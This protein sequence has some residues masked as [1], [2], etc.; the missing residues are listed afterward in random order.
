MLEHKTF[1]HVEKCFLRV[2]RAAARKKLYALR[3]EQDGHTQLA[4]LFRAIVVSEDAQA[5][6]LLL[7]L[8]GQTGNNEQ[9]CLVAFKEEIPSLVEQYE[10]GAEIAAEEGERAMESAF[11]Q[12]AKAE[13]IH[14]NLMSKLDKDP[15]RDKSY[16]VCTF[17]GFIMEEHAPDTC[18]IC[19]APA[20]RFKHL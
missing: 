17:C 13:R 15:A 10:Q 5:I 6:R 20:S 3:A 19:T 18:P 11:Q 12:S 9:N 4:K 16:H 1:T 7:Q 8:R 14:L 2:S